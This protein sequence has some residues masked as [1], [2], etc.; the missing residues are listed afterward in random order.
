VKI[1]FVCGRE[2]GYVRNRLILKAL[3][4]EF[5]VTE[6]SSSRHGF[7]L[8]NLCVLVKCLAHRHEHDLVFVGFY[9]HPLMLWVPLLTHSPIVFDAFLSTYDTLCFDREWF[10]PSSLAGRFAYWLDRHTCALANKVILDTRAHVSYFTKT[11]GL[12]PA[13]FSVLYVGCDEQLFY[14]RQAAEE[15]KFVVFSYGSFLQLHGMEH[16][17]RAAK[18]LEGEPDI[19]FRIGGDGRKRRE[20][21]SLARALGV[22]NVHF[23][24]WIPFAELPTAIAKAS[25]CLGGHFSDSTK[26]GNVIASKTFQFL[27]MAKPTIVTD[28]PA[29]RELFTHGKDVY[30]CRPADSASL[31]RAILD[32]KQDAGLRER[33]ADAGYRVFMA[34]HTVDSISR[35]L[36]QIVGSLDEDLS[37]EP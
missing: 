16:V 2:P 9:G 22:S 36:K 33:I 25:V 28:N 5:E 3:R 12:S 13:K 30:M 8:R 7:I 29:N 21:L 4:R 24:G 1:L 20:V 31:A 18:I 27:A 6:I 17:I 37:R 15:G 26:A 32:L 11:F 19:E 35:S 10:S 34:G 23:G 14:P